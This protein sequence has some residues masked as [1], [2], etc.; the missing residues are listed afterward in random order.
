MD[1]KSTYGELDLRVVMLLMVGIVIWAISPITGNAQDHQIGMRE[2]GQQSEPL[3]LT[4]AI[5]VALA[6]NTQIKRA[7]L[8][9]Q[10]AEQQG[11]IAWSELFPEVLGNASY[12]RNIELPVI[13]FPD[14]QDPE[15]GLRA[16]QIGED[17]NWNGSL[18]IEQT[19]FRGEAIIGVGTLDIFKA[20]QKENLRATSQQIVT[21]TRFAYYDVLIAEE[22][23]RLQQATVDRLRENLR[24]NR[25]RARAGL[26]DE[27]EVLQVEVQ[28]RNQEPQLTEARYAVQRAYRELKLVMGIP[29]DTE[30][31]VR[32]NLGEYDIVSEQA[33]SDQNQHIKKV[34]RMNP[35]TYEES[36]QMLDVASE[37]RGD[38]RILD[39]RTELKESEIRAIKSRYLPSLSTSYRLAW[40]AEEPG[41]PDFFGNSQ[42][43]V[44]IQGISL[45]LEIPIFQGFERDANLEIA[46]IEKKDL[47]LQK[48]FTLRTAKNEIESAR[49]QLNQSIETADARIKALEQAQLGYD[50]ARS[51]L[52]NGIGSQ[53]DVTNAEFQ[54]RQAELNYSRMVYDYLVA[55]ARYDQ[56]VGMVPLVDSEQPN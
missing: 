12:T 56:A 47:Q 19:L 13:F 16:F 36:R 34:D 48:E 33:V 42:Q 32:G 25:A 6:N 51:R 29:L 31:S 23:L 46:R 9:V 7:L 1:Q 44:R 37:L 28:L 41:A 11:R 2:P 3:T 18:T 24:E 54:L 22:Q 40:R 52:E 4:Q 21:E 20:V 35:Y 14:P 27:Y 55:K 45:N 53:L 15:S 50:R 30:F 10:D 39:Q 5:N 49:E 26:I 17:N 43:R 38:I 8:S